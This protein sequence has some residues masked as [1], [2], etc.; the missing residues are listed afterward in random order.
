[1]DAAV[2]EGWLWR[3]FEGMA[4]LRRLWK[5]QWHALR[6][7][8]LYY[9]AG[10]DSTSAHAGMIALKDAKTQIFMHHTRV[11]CFEISH[12]DRRSVCFEAAS[13]E[14]KHEWIQ[15]ICSA[16]LGPVNAPPT[17]KLYFSTLQLEPDATLQ[18][19]R[20][21]FRK[22]ALKSHPDKVRVTHPSQRTLSSARA[23]HSDKGGDVAQFL[24]VTEAYEVLVS[25][26]ETEL[27]EQV[28]SFTPA[29]K[30]LTLSAESLSL[31]AES[32][33]L[34][35]E[36]HTLPAESLTLPAESLP[37]ASLTLPAESLTLPAAG[38]LPRARSAPQA[39]QVP[40]HP[41]IPL[42]HVYYNFV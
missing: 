39:R 13:D 26:R 34:P 35:A 33:T 27:E 32:L 19:I 6:G 38:Q 8:F 22:L 31:P 23:L 17:S 40:T 20:R 37:A 24:L 16:A 28:R 10:S 36:A 5:K 14:N 7:N 2:F 11:H 25:I 42:L 21:A 29:A 4:G 30:S 41:S 3:K 15:H 12:R 9:Y 1:M 18:E